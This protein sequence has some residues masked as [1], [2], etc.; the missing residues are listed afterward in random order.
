MSNLVARIEVLV[1]K[2][3]ITFNKVEHDCKLGNGTIKRWGS[4]SPRLDKLVLVAQY[5]G[6]SLDY[7]VFGTI[8]SD[9]FPNG[10]PF[11]LE[12]YKVEQ[13]LMCD[14]SPLTEMEADLVAMFRL[15]P[16]EAHKEVF[17]YTYFKYKCHVE[18]NVESI[19]STY[20][21]ARGNKKSGHAQ[22]KAQDATA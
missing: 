2:K 8:H 6:V 10:E 7:L 9:S 19:Y 5:L 1:R 12:G 21:D 14:G 20:S 4:Q 11:D 18:K 17:D 13:G 22:G 3:G 15:M 16:D